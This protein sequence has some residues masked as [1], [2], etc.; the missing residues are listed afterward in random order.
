MASERRL[1]LAAGDCGSVDSLG[2]KRSGCA[3]VRVTYSS[4][5]AVQLLLALWR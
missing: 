5:V 4:L 3:W 1:A 2:G